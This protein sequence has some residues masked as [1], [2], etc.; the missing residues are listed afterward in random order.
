[1]PARDGFWLDEDERGAPTPPG[2]GQRD[3]EPAI[4]TP[5]RGRLPERFRAISCWRSISFSR[6]SSCCPRQANRWRGRRQETSPTRD[7]SAVVWLRESIGSGSVPIL[8]HV[9]GVLDNDQTRTIIGTV[10][11]R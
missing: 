6:T 5:S 8:A 10:I 11:F 4:A 9:T 7:N 2:G 3:P 1:M